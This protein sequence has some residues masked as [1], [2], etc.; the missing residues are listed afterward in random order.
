MSAF[1]L[2]TLKQKLWAIVA[3]SFVGRV[4]MFFALPPTASSIQ[5]D[6]INYAVLSKWIAEGKDYNSYPNY[7]TLYLTSRTLILPASKLVA[8]GVNELDAVR[9]ISSA[10]GLLSVIL[11]LV[12]VLSLTSQ[13]GR[14]PSSRYKVLVTGLFATYAFLPS[15]FLWSV[16]GIKESA[17]EFWLISTF[18]GLFLLSRVKKSRKALIAALISVSI[19]CTFSSRPQVG[20]VLVV[21]LLI[22]SLLKIRNKLT[23]LLIPSVLIGSIAGYSAT[24]PF[25]YVT[26]DLYVATPTP[27][28]DST[29]TPTKD[30][31]PTP[32]KDSTPTPTKDSTPSNKG[33]AEV[34]KLC[35]GTKQD[36]KYDGKTYNCIKS[37]TVTKRE[38]STN[39]TELAQNSLEGLPTQQI[40]N[41]VGAASMIERLTCPWNETSEFGKYGC[42]AF[43]APYMTLTFLFRPLPFVDTTS[44]SS[45][46]AATENLL[47]ILMFVLIV[48]RISKIKRIPLFEELAPSIIFFSLYVVGAGSYE[49]NMGTAFRHKSLILWVVLLLLFAFFWRGQDEEKESRGNN[50]QESAV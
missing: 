3:A 36:V 34:S 18:V 15:H 30:S 28:K 24:T 44:L 2:H 35:D 46:F 10:Y 38:R 26:S 17:N 40:I 50:S 6:E 32:T 47:W 8:L 23:F 49:G 25:T 20:W 39:L 33:L 37:G 31:T 41:Q 11:I 12:L 43:R 14:S 1:R 45:A 7:P 9:I 27:T 48:Y 4:I 5:I 13:S 21:A 42:L 22:Y 19:V 16:V 29:P